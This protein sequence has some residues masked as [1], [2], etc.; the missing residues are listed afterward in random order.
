MRRGA[1]EGFNKSVAQNYHDIEAT[2][3]VLLALDILS[4]PE[5]RDKHYRR[6]A[7]SVVMDVTYGFPPLDK[8][9]EM[10]VD[11]FSDEMRRA[12]TPGAHLVELVPWLEYLPAQYANGLRQ[13]CRH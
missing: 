4:A 13:V 1:H 5:A 7:A 2:E 8:N 6:F 3:A 10:L 11:G 12:L 9:E